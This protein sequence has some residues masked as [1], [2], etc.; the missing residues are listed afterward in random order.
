[1]SLDFARNFGCQVRKFREHVNVS[2]ACE[3]A[4]L[5]DHIPSQLGTAGALKW[6]H[7]A[8]LNTDARRRGAKNFGIAR[9]WTLAQ[10]PGCNARALHA[11]MQTKNSSPISEL[12]ATIFYSIIKL[13]S[14]EIFFFCFK[15]HVG[16]QTIQNFISLFSRF[17]KTFKNSKAPRWAPIK[18]TFTI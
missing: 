15:P 11:K 12:K 3:C 17:H 5:R 18:C 10:A 2:F 7:V 4:G 8:L 6:A 9:T 13:Q 14:I 1:M 16:R